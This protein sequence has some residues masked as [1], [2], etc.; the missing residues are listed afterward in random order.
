MRNLAATELQLPGPGAG[1]FLP[2]QREQHSHSASSAT[3]ES[4]KLEPSQE[5]GSLFVRVCLGIINGGHP[6]NCL[7]CFYLRVKLLYVGQRR[8]H[9]RSEEDLGGGGLRSADN[10]SARVNAAYRGPSWVMLMPRRGVACFLGA[11]DEP[12]SPGACEHG[13]ARLS[14]PPPPLCVLSCLAKVSPLATICLLGKQLPGR[15][16]GRE[17]SANQDRVAPRSRW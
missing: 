13:G 14:C 12:L 1:R 16:S 15:R 9:L 5:S 8:I 6:R 3:S 4:W 7:L 11:A 17:G 2:A 10:L